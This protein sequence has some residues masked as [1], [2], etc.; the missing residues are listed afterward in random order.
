MKKEKYGTPES[1]NPAISKKYKRIIAFCLFI[2][3]IFVICHYFVLDISTE[4]FTSEL[5]DDSF[6]TNQTEDTYLGSSEW[7]FDKRLANYQEN[8]ESLKG[9]ITNILILLTLGVLLIF[10]RPEGIT[11]P[12]ISL[13]IPE[14]PLYFVIVFGAFY[15]WSNF[16]LELNSAIISRMTL[17]N[18]LEVLV[19]TPT[20][21]SKKADGKSPTQILFD[22]GVVDNW[23]V[24]YFPE[25]VKVEG[26]EGVLRVWSTFGLYGLYGLMAGALFALS[27]ITSVEFG[28][29][30]PKLKG[31]GTVLL[32]FSFLLT[33]IPTVLWGLYLHRYS[34]IYIGYMWLVTAL[35]IYLWHTKGFH[36]AQELSK[37]LHPDSLSNDKSE[38]PQTS[39]TSN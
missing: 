14:M 26:N 27:I 36:L 12:V 25:E 31:P 6:W 32:I 11:I 38:Q 30:M 8:L 5:K 18:N 23:V 19:D 15:A 1:N 22:Q 4:E 29:R 7:I 21:E 24:H 17:H 2:S 35:G 37:K 33:L 3:V 34:S 28:R 9:S 20:D 10:Y 39:D 16:G 13:K